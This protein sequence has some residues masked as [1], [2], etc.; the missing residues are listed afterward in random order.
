MPG[1]CLIF[2]KKDKKLLNEIYEKINIKNNEDIIKINKD[3][4][5]H[6]SL[7]RTIYKKNDEV[8]INKTIKKICKKY[9]INKFNIEGIGIFPNKNKFNLHFIVAYNKNMNKI[10]QEVWKELNGKIETIEKDHYHPSSFVP[11]ITIPIVKQS[12]NKTL[13]LKIQNELLNYDIRSIKLSAEYLSHLT[14]N[15]NTPKVYYKSKFS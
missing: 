8:I 3:L 13:L 5:P 9:K 12:N 4:E 10:H 6:I 15:L 7:Y 11:H 2:S 14:G 1:I